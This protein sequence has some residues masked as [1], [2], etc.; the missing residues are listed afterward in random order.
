MIAEEAEAT[1]DPADESLV[2]VFLQTERPNIWLT[3]LHCA[4]QL[5]AGRGEDEDVV[6]EAD[7]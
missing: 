3:H 2:W 7:M 6:H 5:P 4:A 1:F